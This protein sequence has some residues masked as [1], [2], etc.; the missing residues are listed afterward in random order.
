MP[1]PPIGRRFVGRGRSR[2]RVRRWIEA[3]EGPRLTIVGPAGIGKTR[4][5]R[6][7]LRSVVGCE[8]AWASATPREPA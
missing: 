5:L 4:L 6:E 3:S 7:A 2:E 8:V 1:S